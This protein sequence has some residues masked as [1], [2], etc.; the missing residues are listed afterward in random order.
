MLSRSGRRA[1]CDHR[2][3]IAIVEGVYGDLFRDDVAHR[4]C[5]QFFVG[6]HE[7]I[8]SRKDAKAPRS[9]TS[10]CGLASLREIIGL[11]P[12]GNEVEPVMGSEKGDAVVINAQLVAAGVH[13]HS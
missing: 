12:P 8:I 13:I 4:D 1:G 2:Y 9:E 6:I 3:C 5:D 10:L 11:A 7:G